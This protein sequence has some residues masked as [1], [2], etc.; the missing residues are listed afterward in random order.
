MPLRFGQNQIKRVGGGPTQPRMSISDATSVPVSQ[1]TKNA[2]QAIEFNQSRTGQQNVPSTTIAQNQA[3]IFVNKA[4]PVR[5]SNAQGLNSVN[6]STK[7]QYQLCMLPETSKNPGKSRQSPRGY[8]QS[9]NEE[10][11][12]K[13]QF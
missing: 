11:R 2:W 8:D 7:L 5:G 3:S 9:S 1:T 10:A 13:Q 6:V 12:P 4:G